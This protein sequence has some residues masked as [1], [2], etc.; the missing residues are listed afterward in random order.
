M[1]INRKKHKL[2]IHRKRRIRAKISGAAD[3]PRLVVHRSNTA[4]YVQ[5][6]NDDK[7][8]TLTSQ[9]SKKKNKEAARELGLRI[10]KAA[11]E[12]GISAVVFD[13]GG[14]KYH[15][16]IKELADAAREGGLQF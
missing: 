1:D 6:I 13:R 12:K 15:G 4:L 16:S 10:A 8:I 7:G 2:A 11:K 5:L 9:S 14:Y 3:R